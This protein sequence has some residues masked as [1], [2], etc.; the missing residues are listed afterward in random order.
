LNISEFDGCVTLVQ[1]SCTMFRD[2]KLALSV[3]QFSQSVSLIL[4][5]T[6]WQCLD[7]YS[8]MLRSTSHCELHPRFFDGI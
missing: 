2:P 7:Q 5:N 3:D 4:V 1:E 6:E 8:R